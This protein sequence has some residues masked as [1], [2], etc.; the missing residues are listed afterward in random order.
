MTK[1]HNIK[2]GQKAEAIA[3]SFLKKK[4][5]N[6]LCQNYRSSIGEIDIIAKERDIIVFI[7]VK[8]RTNTYYGLPKEAVTYKKQQQIIRTALWYL[9]EKNFFNC[10][11]TRFDVVSILFNNNQIDIEHIK[12]AFQV[13]NQ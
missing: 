11:K 9:N 4:G 12:A 7:E 13:E 10:P 3:V 1:K 6:I 5:F 2:L 8:A